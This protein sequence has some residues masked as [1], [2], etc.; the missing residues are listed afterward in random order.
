MAEKHQHDRSE[1]RRLALQVLYQA[2]I[3]ETDP[4]TIIEEGRL[5]DETQLLGNY[6]RRLI[7]GATADQE[8][9][10]AELVEASEN[11]ALDRMPVVD[12]SLLRMAA[13]EMRS[14][15]EVP[16]SVSI[17][18]AVNLAKEFGGE[19]SPRF[20]NGILGRIARKRMS[21]ANTESFEEVKRRLDEIV[22]AVADDDLPLDDALKLYEEAVQLGLRA[23]SLLEEN[24]Q[25]NN[26]LYDEERSEDVQDAGEEAPNASEPDASVEPALESN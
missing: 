2:E 23:S 6:A 25:E 20:V 14:V 8:A 5:V 18:E 11:W 15:D 13:Y 19:D 22:D 9:I 12:R 17:N 24:L 3:L 26:A 16:I 7:E 21:E 10:D 4:A 1:A